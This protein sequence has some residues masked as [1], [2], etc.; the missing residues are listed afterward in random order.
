MSVP[1]QLSAKNTVPQ[2]KICYFSHPFQYF[3]HL[4]ITFKPVIFGTEVMSFKNT[5]TLECQVG[6]EMKSYSLISDTKVRL[7]GCHRG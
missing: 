3:P 2:T 6:R 5:S 1:C 7:N 4:L